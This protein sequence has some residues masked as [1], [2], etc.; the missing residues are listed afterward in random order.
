MG[1][2]TDAVS[3]PLEGSWGRPAVPEPRPP[4]PLLLVRAGQRVAQKLSFPSTLL[5]S[6]SLGQAGA[7]CPHV[8]SQRPRELHLS[9]SRG[10]REPAGREAWRAAGAGLPGAEG[11][12]LPPASSRPCPFPRNHSQGL[13]TGRLSWGPRE[14]GRVRTGVALCR[15][16]EASAAPAPAVRGVLSVGG[17]GLRHPA[18]HG[19]VCPRT[20]WAAPAPLASVTL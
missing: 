6:G 15:G 5:L 19:T 1:G 8:S 20:L 2:H 14:A 10:G 18:P 12:V 7:S 16:A 9:P 17:S 11:T 4:A 3:R 13:L